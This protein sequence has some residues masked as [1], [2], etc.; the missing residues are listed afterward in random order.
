MAWTISALLVVCVAASSS[1][2]GPGGK[3]SPARR[4]VLHCL[5][6]LRV[7]LALKLSRR[8]LRRN[9]SRLK[10]GHDVPPSPL[11]DQPICTGEWLGGSS[12]GSPLKICFPRR[13]L[14]YTCLSDPPG[15]GRPQENIPRSPLHASQTDGDDSRQCLPTDRQETGF[16]SP[17]H[18]SDEGEEKEKAWTDPASS[19]HNEAK[20]R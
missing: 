20:K 9:R 17:S 18:T 2:E 15:S 7:S 1:P 10:T 5:T 11:R 6:K 14:H 4:S 8:T 3:C 19:L 13:T 12:R 16:P